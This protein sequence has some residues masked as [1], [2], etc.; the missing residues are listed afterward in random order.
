MLLLDIRIRLYNFCSTSEDLV[1]FWNNILPWCVGLSA[2]AVIHLKNLISFRFD[3][4]QEDD[5][6]DTILNP[7]DD[8]SPG[9]S[10]ADQQEILELWWML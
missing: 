9:I 8:P 10:L 7:T 5:I 3:E 4:V 1:G 6:E 2:L